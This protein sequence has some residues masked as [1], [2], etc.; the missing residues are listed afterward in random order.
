MSELGAFSSPATLRKVSSSGTGSIGKPAE[1]TSLR[2]DRGTASINRVEH[3]THPFPAVSGAAAQ[4]ASGLVRDPQAT[5]G[6]TGSS[7]GGAGFSS[8]STAESSAHEAFA[9][10]DADT[11]SSGPNW[12]HAGTRRAEAGYQDPALGWIGVRADVSGGGVHATLLPSSSEAAQ[13]LGGHMAGLDA[14]LAAEH[15]SVRSLTLTTPEGSEP[16]LASGQDLGQGMNQESGQSGYSEPQPGS[17]AS[18]AAI[19]TSVSRDTPAQSGRLDHATEIPRLGG[20]H[21]SVVA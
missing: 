5:R 11:N 7:P 1:Q 4:D 20:T 15:T 17:R 10:L 2:N 3:L 6:M 16:G 8:G 19:A 13:V 14:Y 12:I 9:A 21:I 18:M